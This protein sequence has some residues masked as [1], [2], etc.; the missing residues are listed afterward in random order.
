MKKLNH[1]ICVAVF[2]QL[3]GCGQGTADGDRVPEVRDRSIVTGVVE[4]VLDKLFVGGTAESLAYGIAVETTVHHMIQK[5]VERILWKYAD[6]N[7]TGRGWAVVMQTDGAILALADCGYPAA[8]NAEGQTVWKPAA[9]ADP[10]EPGSVIKPIT[11]ALALEDRIVEIDSAINT[12]R[13]DP[14]YSQL[15]LPSDGGRE[16][17]KAMTVGEAVVKSSNIV[18]GKIGCDLGARR[19]C[20]GFRMFGLGRGLPMIGV[21]RD[22]E[23][24]F[25]PRFDRWSRAMRSR[26][27][28]GQGLCLSGL[29]LAR[30]YSV[31]AN[32]GRLV[33]PFL[34]RR[35]RDREGHVFYEHGVTPGVRVISEQTAECMHQILME[36]AG[37]G[38]TGHCASGGGLPVAGK[39]G[40][41][42]RTE[43]YRPLEGRYQATFAGYYPAD[44]PKFVIVVKFETARSKGA[45]LH[46]GGGRSALAFADLVRWLSSNWVRTASLL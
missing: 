3:V 12:N 32:K 36:A 37:A 15:Q 34:V 44:N 2:S 27:P 24:C 13:K 43:G 10:Y 39:T 11:A 16:W 35:I 26:I 19:V 6:T 25:I 9:V 46:Q 18:M 31:F 7:D 45:S 20:E 38:G 4:R 22:G 30:A 33:E 21:G 23:T 14:R 5:E 42:L 8:T 28:I 40:T 41:V 17:G 1:I 29:E